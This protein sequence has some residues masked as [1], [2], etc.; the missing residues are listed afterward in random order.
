MLKLSQVGLTGRLQDITVSASSGQFIHL[1]GANGAGKSSLLA[2]IAGLLPVDDGRIEIMRQ[3]I[4]EFSLGQLA[5]FRC[6]QEQQQR[7]AFAITV[8]ESL[9]FFTGDCNIP[10][11]LSDTLEI[12]EFLQRP[13]GQLSGGENRRV[14]IARCLLQIW[15]AIEQGQGLI[16]LDEPVQGLDFRHQHLL[17]RL[18]QK[19]AADG[20]VILMSHHD[21][22]LCQQYANRLWLMADGRLIEQPEGEAMLDINVLEKVFACGVRY[23]FDQQGNKIFQTYLD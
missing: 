6:L 15:P 13:L 3:A 4:N 16:L 17:C 18:L 20:N 7:S 23:L 14:H 8:E 10:A 21:L 22:N 5:Q 2:V 12:S 11:M 9:R 19:L 1:L